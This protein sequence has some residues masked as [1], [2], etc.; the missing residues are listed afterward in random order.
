MRSELTEAVREAM[1]PVLAEMQRDLRGVQGEYRDTARAAND[2]ANQQR[3]AAQRVQRGI[4]GITNEQRRLAT[5]AS[6]TGLA[7]VRALRSTTNA[8]NAQARAWDRLAAAKARAAAV[9]NPDA[10]RGP[11]PRTPASGGR[12]GARGG[13]GRGGAM[14]FLTG[15]VGLNTIALGAAGIPAATTAVVNLVGAI[16]QLS[17]AGL[18]LPGIF[19]SIAASAGTAVIGFKGMGDAVSALW[20]AAA[21]GDPKDLE[22]ATEALKDMAPAAVEVAKAVVGQRD[23]FIELRKS[24]QQNMFAGVATDLDNLANKQLPVVR[25][26]LDLTSKAWN[27]TIREVLRVGASNKVSGILDRIFG[28]TAEGQK[29]AN[30]AIEPLVSAFGQLAAVGSDFI[31]RLADGLT[32]LANR[33]NNFITKAD[34]TGDLARWIDEGFKAAANLG[35]SL[36]NIGKIITD[37]TKAAGGDG[38]FLQWL[39]DATARLHEFLS[40]DEGQEKLTKFFTDGK[41][42]LRQWMP[43]LR[44]LASVALQVLEGFR[45]WGSVILPIVGSIL[46]GLTGLPD[47]IQAVVVAFL[48]WKTMTGITGLATKLLG[49]G[50]SIDA[51]PG[52]AT[53][54]VS[55][56]NKAFGALSLGAL[57]ANLGS[58]FINEGNTAAGAATNILGGAATGAMI[59]GPWGAAIGALIGTGVTLFE[60]GRKQ[61]DEGKA[62]W[63]KAWQRDHD[64]GPNREGSPERQMEAVPAIKGTMMPSFYNPDGTLKPSIGQDM[65]AK[66]AAGQF[67]GLSLGPNG[68]VLQNGVPIP[69]L[70]LPPA[71]LPPV[72]GPPVPAP[73]PAAAPDRPL[74]V[75]IVNPLPGTPPVPPPATPPVVAPSTVGGLLGG[76]ELPEVKAQVADIAKEVTQLPEGEVK[77]KDPSPEVLENLKKLD[78]QIENTGKDEITVKANTDT[79]Q[80]TIDAFVRKY[81]QQQF[82]LAF[83]A[84]VNAPALPPGRADGGVLPGYS[85]GRDNMLYPLSGGEGILIPEAVR[86]LGGPA[87]IYSINSRFRAGLSRRG[88]ADGGVHGG[89]GAFPGPEGGDPIVGLLTQIRDLLAGKGGTGPLVDTAQAVQNIDQSATSTGTQTGPFGTPIK[90][91]HRGYEMAAAAI[92][93]LGGDPE[94]FL[95]ADPASLSMAQ[96]GILPNIASAGI[97]GRTP[98]VAALQKF[99]RTGN[100]ADLPAGL[101]LNDPVVTAITAARNKKK[102]LGDDALASLIGQSLG[103]GGFTGTLD[104][105]N[106]SVVKALTKYRDKLAKTGGLSTSAATAATATGGLPMAGLGGM[107]PISMYAAQHSGGQYSWGSSDLAAGLSDCSGAVSDLV[108][109]IT[110]GQA[111]SKRLFSTADAGSVLSS[112]GAVS[113]AVPGALQIG[114]SDSHMRATLPNGVN[115]ESGGGTGQGATYGGNAQGA[116]GMPNIMSLPAGGLAGGLLATNGAGGTPVFVT[117]WPGQGGGI[118]G[119]ILGAALG[120]GGDAAAGVTGD[121]LSG[122]AGGL[123]PTGPRKPSADLLKLVQERNPMALLAAMGF[124]VQDFSKAGNPNDF[125]RPDEAFDASGRLFSD[126]GALAD[127]TTT[128]L[129]AQIDALRQQLTDA[130][131]QVADKLTEDALKPVIESAIQSGMEGLKDSVSQQIGTALGNAAAPPIADAVRSA[132]PTQA[133]APGDGAVEAVAG[134][135]FAGGGGVGG[136]YLGVDSVPAMLM[137]GEHVLTRGDVA[138]MGG[139]ANVYAFRRALARGGI[140]GYATGGG[141]NVNDTVGAEFFGV[142]EIPILGAIV[143]L[144][145]RV[146]LKVLGVEIEARDTLNEMTGEFRQFRGDFKAFDATGRLMNDTSALVERSSTSEQ[147]AAQERI[148]ILKIVIEAL[149]KYIIEKVIVPITKAVA[150]A[151]IQAGASAAGAAVNTQAPGAGGIV[152]SL[153]SSAGSAGVDIAAEIGT[154]IALAITSVA[155]EAIGEAI[156]SYFPD[157]ANA[158]FG[159]GVIEQFLVGPLTS[160][161]TDPILGAIGGL[162]S[163]FAGLFGGAA[164]LIPGL[165]FDNGGVANGTGMMPKATIAPERVLSPQQTVMWDRMIAALEKGNTLGGNR[166]IE[167]HAPI[168]VQGGMDAG[169]SVQESI[170]DMVNG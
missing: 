68:T 6:A 24:V 16:Q 39:N 108:E 32:N 136:P 53:T 95:G 106:T 114:W 103:P 15:P 145:V 75:Q 74:P 37:L 101:S 28:N 113:G 132:I 1:A 18:V 62:E 30:A 51:L 36:L 71:A 59:G 137:P 93:A 21:S 54:A 138:A 111:T 12:G 7:Q 47:A 78:V 60:L 87:G 120:A 19:A 146:L 147:A 164:S 57:T 43:I 58:N 85:P 92:S 163:V 109:L 143:N 110:Q 96:G 77:I 151:A 125:A 117:N 160:F 129:S 158:V 70:N 170:L 13:G 168:T 162:F 4:H 55:R 135:A 167:V 80:A 100:V 67:P 5:Q 10:P 42:Q 155:V 61:L 64:A 56:M 40:S 48:A 2:S 52:R 157:L 152:S 149:I 35:N 166:T 8:I 127:R 105:D 46:S 91:R 88:Y 126:T 118:G 169:K 124:D 14:G 81:Q 156:M 29:R 38:G 142:S 97:G 161:I 73:P 89:T 41:E 123:G 134:A 130:V 131:D 159:G 44:D 34:Q 20:E 25:R 154:D 22:K 128:S 11:P 50:T 72:Q 112:L 83:N 139:Q 66:I 121:V 86:A 84:T 116:A 102:G 45:E 115:F 27:A 99:A 33:F 69:G 150:N 65:T 107:D 140:R 9:P 94:K 3:L 119:N 122:I 144:L 31:P 98:D 148:R 79:A 153:I 141:V 17:Q 133:A 82:N 26:G 49:I 63:E 90:P 76:A 104:S 165:P 23:A